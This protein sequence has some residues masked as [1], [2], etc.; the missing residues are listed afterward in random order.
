MLFPKIIKRLTLPLL[1][2]YFAA[3]LAFS[4]TTRAAEDPPLGSDCGD[5]GCFVEDIQTVVNF[6]SAGVGIV[7]VAMII[8]G[9][10]QYTM[11][12]DNPQAVSEAK[13]RIK[14]ALFGLLAYALTFA[15]LNWLIPGGVF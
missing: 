15:F 12:G 2:F 5:A 1:L 14:N 9:G 7:V 10:I 8:I 6:L 4:K 3:A 11:A 13:S